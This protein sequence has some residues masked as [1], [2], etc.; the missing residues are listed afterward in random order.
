MKSSE[1]SAIL[2][3]GIEPSYQAIAVDEAPPLPLQLRQP[4]AI[5]NKAVRSVSL[6]DVALQKIDVKVASRTSEHHKRRTTGY[7]S[8]DFSRR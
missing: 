4:A 1:E 5:R 6:D 8:L 3:I 7:E 2:Q